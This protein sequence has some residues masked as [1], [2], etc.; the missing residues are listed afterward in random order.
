MSTQV[1]LTVPDDLY[2]RVE[3]V[4]TDTRRRVDELLIESI[5]RSFAVGSA[6]P[7]RSAMEANVAAYRRLHPK[8]VK[9]HLGQ[10]VAIC[11]GKLVDYDLDP[12]SLLGRIRS[13]FPG[14]T[15]LRR[16]VDA[17]VEQE[18]RIRHPRIE[19]VT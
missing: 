1:V 11:E 5:T 14:Q 12:V 8:L 10:Y 7:A 15:V 6:D 9:T 16:K 19:V 2:Q 13:R 18:I 17:V 3:A 4:A